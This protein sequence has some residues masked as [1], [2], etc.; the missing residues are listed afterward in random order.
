MSC[1]P[2]LYGYWLDAFSEWKW[3]CAERKFFLFRYR[4]PGPLDPYFYCIAM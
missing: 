1:P 4:K 2:F 3:L